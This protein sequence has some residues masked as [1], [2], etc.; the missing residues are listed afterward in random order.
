MSVGLKIGDVVVRA[1]S[2]EGERFV[3]I[4]GAAVP[5]VSWAEAYARMTSTGLYV[6]PAGWHVQ[7]LDNGRLA[8]YDAA[9]LVRVGNLVAET[10]GLLPRPRA[11]V[12][13]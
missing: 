3:V 6:K 8:T 1:E 13:A 10:E 5:A 9:A 7:S 11:K 2:P 12:G 4:H